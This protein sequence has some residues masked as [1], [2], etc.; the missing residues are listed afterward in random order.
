MVKQIMLVIMLEEGMM[1]VVM[2]GMM[3]VV[4]VEMMVVVTVEMVMM[5]SHSIC[6]ENV[7]ISLHFMLILIVSGCKTN[8]M[9]DAHHSKMHLVKLHFLKQEPERNILK[10]QTDCLTSRK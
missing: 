5:I 7:E 3:I 8:L 9:V 2:V 6:T 4:M 1:M 10:E